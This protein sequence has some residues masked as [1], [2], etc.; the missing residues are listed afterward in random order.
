[1]MKKSTVVWLMVAALIGGSLLT[2]A[3]TGATSL[4]KQTAGEGIL[5]S[6]SNN[7]DKQSDLDKIQKALD[8]IQNNYYQ[9]VDRTKLVD[10]AINGMMEALGDP[11][12]NY[13]GKTTAAQF[14]E[15]IEGSFTGIGAEVS[16]ENGKV[17]IVSPIKNSPAEKAGLRA[18]D[19]ILTV[20]GT[21]LA[22]MELNDAVNKIRGPKGSKAVLQIQRAGSTDPLEYTIVRDDIDLETVHSEMKPNGI[23]VITITQFSLNTGQRFKEELAKLEAQK[24][25]GLVIDVRNNPGGVLSVVIDIAQQFV[26]KGKVIVQVEDK[27]KQREKEQ[28]QGG[29]KSYPIALLMNKGSASASEILAG[30][31][32]QSAGATLIGENSF[33]K[34]TVQTSYDKQ[35]GD[36][37]LLKITIAKWLTPDGSWIHKK[38]IKPDIAVDQPAYFTVAPLAKDKTLK[39]DMNSSDVKNAQ[40][41]LTGLGYKPGRQDG[42][43]D[44]ATE[45]AVKAF[46]TKQKL[47]V[48]GTIDAKT[49][50]A[51]EAKLVESIRDPRNDTQLNKG[52]EFVGKEIAASASK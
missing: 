39:Y 48:S 15:Q 45:Q 26:P 16:S 14:E 2:F 1:M 40:V 21:S 24:M 20:N 47:T 3:F 38:G 46:Q 34:G 37:S 50:S 31:L 32:Q 19:I 49:A 29:G 25:K 10:G 43:F 27:N 4:A 51:L 41:M 36:G 8:L 6:I 18:K 30:A 5:A 9:E 33:G 28:S 12:S 11:Y 22:G 35:M 52:L 7:V 42:Y 44:R 17:T 23:G 13:M